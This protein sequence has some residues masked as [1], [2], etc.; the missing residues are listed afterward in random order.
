MLIPNV[1]THNHRCNR[2]GQNKL[3]NHISEWLYTN[4]SCVC[5]C[6][7][8][9]FGFSWDREEEDCRHRTAHAPPLSRNFHFKCFGIPRFA[10]LPF[11]FLCLINH[12]MV[13][14]L[15][16]DLHRNCFMGVSQKS[17]LVSKWVSGFPNRMWWN[18]AKH[19]EGD[20]TFISHFNSHILYWAASMHQAF[21]YC[22]TAKFWRSQDKR[23][24]QYNDNLILESAAGN[25]I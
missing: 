7:R 12:D 18:L 2:F 24:H 17:P 16:T 15:G 19:T 4:A 9:L 5:C 20:V 10:H 13:F 3:N 22:Q 14:L 21:F 11:P 6:L 8:K 1:C 25:F 23:S